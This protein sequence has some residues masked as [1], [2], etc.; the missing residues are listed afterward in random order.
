MKWIYQLFCGNDK[1]DIRALYALTLWVGATNA[2]TIVR[3]CKDEAITKETTQNKAK[4][5]GTTTTDGDVVTTAVT[6]PSGTL[7]YKESYRGYE[8]VG[9]WT[10]VSGELLDYIFP[11]YY[12]SQIIKEKPPRQ[13]PPKP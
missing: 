13:R 4:F 8:P 3:Y 5:I 1:T 6:Y 11:L 2:Q 7:R 10:L 9:I 12:Q